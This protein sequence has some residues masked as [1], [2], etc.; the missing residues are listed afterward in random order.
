MAEPISIVLNGH[1]L[2]VVIVESIV[3]MVSVCDLE[4]VSVEPINIV[5]SEYDLNPIDPNPALFAHVVFPKSGLIRP[6]KNGNFSQNFHIF[7]NLNP[8]KS[9]NRS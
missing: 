1:N 3:I 4:V 6:W 8:T 9:M 5:V 2:G 7:P